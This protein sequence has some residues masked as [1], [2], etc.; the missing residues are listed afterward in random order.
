MSAPLLTWNFEAMS[1]ITGILLRT[2]LSEPI[3]AKLED[4]VTFL[5][6]MGYRQPRLVSKEWERWTWPGSYPLYYLCADGGVLCSKCA[7][8]NVKMTS[9]P[10]AERD[11]R[12]VGAD[13]NWED[14]HLVCDH[15][16]EFCESAYGESDNE[17]PEPSDAEAAVAIPKEL[18]T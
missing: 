16:G 17:G 3:D 14:T 1:T 2:D 8:E 13:V 4:L 6:G 7:N 5:E 9:D 10:E 15:C 12:I 11:W 18:Q